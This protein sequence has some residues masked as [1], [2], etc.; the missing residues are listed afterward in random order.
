MGQTILRP[1][2]SMRSIN[3]APFL[4]V[5]QI[6]V[7]FQMRYLSLSPVRLLSSST[8]REFEWTQNAPEAVEEKQNRMHASFYC[9][10]K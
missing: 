6:R 2:M 8:N 1:L 7:K 3:L 5:S 9:A 10:L 4:A